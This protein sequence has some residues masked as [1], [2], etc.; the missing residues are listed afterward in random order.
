MHLHI[1]FSP[2]DKARLTAFEKNFTM[3]RLNNAI[4]TQTLA[5][6]LCT[7]PPLPPPAPQPS[8]HTHM[9]SLVS[10]AQ[11]GSFLGR[12]V[13]CLLSLWVVFWYNILFIYIDTIENNENSSSVVRLI[14]VGGNSIRSKVSK[15]SLHGQTNTFE[16]IQRHIQLLQKSMALG[17]RLG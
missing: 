12:R 3:C 15:W 13:V 1:L 17:S 14:V 6:V 10:G 9:S 16:P 4:R 5:G 11:L 2:N 7:L 8:H